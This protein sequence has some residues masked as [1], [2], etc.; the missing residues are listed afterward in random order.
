MTITDNISN[1][2]NAPASPP[3]PAT[4]PLLPDVHVVTYISGH[5]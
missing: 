1:N 3:K 4:V 2:I 5:I